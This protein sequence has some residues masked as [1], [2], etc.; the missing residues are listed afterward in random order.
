MHCHAEIF[1]SS[2]DCHIGTTWAAVGDRVANLY[3][4]NRPEAMLSSEKLR[5]HGI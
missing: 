4:V 5:K 3:Q 1:C 2:T